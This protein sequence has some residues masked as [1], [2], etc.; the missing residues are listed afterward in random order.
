MQN[1]FLNKIIADLLSQSSDLSRFKIVLP[2]KRPIVFIKKILAENRYSGLLPDFFTVEEIVQKI[3]NQQPIQ[4]IALWL[5]AFD[6][7][8][9]LY[10]ENFENFLKWFPTLQ[11]DWDD[12]LK[13]SDNEN[14]VLEYM[15]AEERIKNWGETI[16]DEQSKTRQRNLDFW[17]KMVV[18]LPVLKQK[19][20]EQN[21]ATSGMLHE[22]A[23]QKIKDFAQNTEGGFVFCGFNAFTPLEELLVKELLQWDK[24]QCF[25]QA[26]QYYL[27]D[28]RQE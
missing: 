23:K 8:R 27:D 1:L 13:F 2:G 15:F 14:E 7:Y 25:F 19:L 12:I 9:G 3:A 6:V 4:G 11:K 10:E 18:F 22:L 16:G 21:L 17:K 24:A 20:Q 26:D 5:F 28:E